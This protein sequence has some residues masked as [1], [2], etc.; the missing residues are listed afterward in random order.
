[1]LE[2]TTPPTGPPPLLDAEVHGDDS[3]VLVSSMSSVTNK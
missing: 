2:A 1:M 3:H